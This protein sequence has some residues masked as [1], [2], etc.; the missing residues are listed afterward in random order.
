M[1][2]DKPPNSPAVKAATAKARKIQKVNPARHKPTK[3]PPTSGAN[4]VQ[5]MKADAEAR[6]GLR[7]S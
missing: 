5:Q 4:A 1:S 7:A 2:K 6:Q 3:Y